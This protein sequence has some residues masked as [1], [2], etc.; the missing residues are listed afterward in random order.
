MWQHAKQSVWNSFSL[1]RC[2]NPPAR[3]PSA[4]SQ[5]ASL[6]RSWKPW[7]RWQGVGGWQAGCLTAC[8]PSWWP[9][10]KTARRRCATTACLASAAWP[11]RPDPSSCRILFSDQAQPL[12]F[13]VWRLHTTVAFSLADAHRDYP[14]M[15]SVFSKLL[16]KESDRRVIDNLCAAL[17][18]M[19]MTNVDAVPL[20]QVC[21]SAHARD[22]HM[23]AWVWSDWKCVVT[24]PQV[25]PALVERLPLKEDM[26]ENK[27]VFSCLAMLYTH[28]PSLVINKSWYV[29]CTCFEW[30]VITSMDHILLVDNLTKCP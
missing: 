1:Y 27:T 5:S 13:A 9:E 19:I 17:C 24:F 29:L 14:M 6:G 18:R 30:N 15:L 22:P 3:T 16:T 21:F 12:L 7:L 11:R 8:S 28:S 20:E 26:E 25:V 10:W 23:T 4:P 2:R